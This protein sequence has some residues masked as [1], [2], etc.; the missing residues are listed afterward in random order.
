[1]Q[2][3]VVKVVKKKLPSFGL[4]HSNVKKPSSCARRLQRHGPPEQVVDHRLRLGVE[5]REARL[6]ITALVMSPKCR[7]RDVDRGTNWSHL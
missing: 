2:R 7:D 3:T 4:E 5:L 6:H 1:M